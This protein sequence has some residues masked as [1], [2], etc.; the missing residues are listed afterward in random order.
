MMEFQ[1]VPIAYTPQ[2]AL[3]VQNTMFFDN[4]MSTISASLS[5]CLM[6]HSGHFLMSV[7]KIF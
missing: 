3:G 5:D 6:R 7:L 2:V 1:P 4:I